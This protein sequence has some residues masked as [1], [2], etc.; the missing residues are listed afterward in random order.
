MKLAGARARVQAEIRQLLPAVYRPYEGLN[1]RL[2]EDPILDAWRGAAGFARDGG[3]EFD[4]ACVSRQNYE[5][6]GPEYLKEHAASNVYYKRPV[7]PER[8]SKRRKR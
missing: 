1:V 3:E 8:E 2:A 4:D 6:M 5:E 7:D